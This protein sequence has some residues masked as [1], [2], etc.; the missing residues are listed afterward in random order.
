MATLQVSHPS[1]QGR[2]IGI[3]QAALPLFGLGIA[4]ILVTQLLQVVAWHWIFALVS[5]PGLLVAWWLHRTLRPA[6]TAGQTVATSASADRSSA[7]A[8]SPSGEAGQ[9]A[10]TAH[11][12]A[13]LRHRNVVLGMV[14]ML[15]WLTNLVVLSAML[16]S[17]LTD[18][19]RLTVEQMGWVLSAIGF[20]GTLGTLI[21]PALSDR[22]GRKPVMIAS[23]LG[24]GLG[25][26]LF[27]HTGADPQRLFAGLFIALFFVFS[28]ICL[29]VGPLSAESVP[30]HLMSTASG[31]VI[32]VGEIFGG[33]IAPVIAGAVAEHFG[34][35]RIMHL[36]AWALALGLL[37]AV[38]V[39][40]TAPGR[41]R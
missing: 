1:R 5:L 30:P 18:H 15:C 9:R 27:M 17:Y 11:W 37:V 39:R 31:L 3:Q 7:L 19:L 38:L 28:L 33:G 13:V 32:G 34:I 10:P 16:P 35:D 26:A 8:I 40:E 2:N 14:G 24:A 21:M 12:H 4:P 23:V 29:T 20:G 41:R 6:E 36:A 25:L 22:C